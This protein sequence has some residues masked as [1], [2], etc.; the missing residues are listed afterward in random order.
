[1]SVDA[2]ALIDGRSVPRYAEVRVQP[3]PTASATPVRMSLGD[4]GGPGRDSLR[5]RIFVA[6]SSPSAGVALR[7]LA[8]EA[9]EVVRGHDGTPWIEPVRRVESWTPTISTATITSN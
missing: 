3:D 9:I 2:P 6:T 4:R 1:M 7:I 5:P 8:A